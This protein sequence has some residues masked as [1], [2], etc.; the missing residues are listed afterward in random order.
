ML[1]YY[2][3][4]CANIVPGTMLPVCKLHA[5]AETHHLVGASPRSVVAQASPAPDGPKVLDCKFLI[6]LLDLCRHGQAWH[7]TTASATAT[8][9]L[10]VRGCSVGFPT[11]TACCVPC[12]LCCIQDDLILHLGLL[13]R[14]QLGCTVHLAEPRQHCLITD[15]SMGKWA[16]MVQN[17]RRAFRTLQLQYLNFAFSS[18][19]L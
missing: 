13:H 14:Q 3:E 8:F 10:T 7:C 17:L 18:S 12:S 15:D 4:Y 6:L 2:W 5:I 11:S 19:A 9:F 16:C 1:L